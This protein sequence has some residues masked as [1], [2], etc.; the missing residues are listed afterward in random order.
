[1]LWCWWKYCA[2]KGNE[3]CDNDSRRW[4][5]IWHCSLEKGNSQGPQRSIRTY[6]LRPLVL[7]RL[8]CWTW[9]MPLV[10]TK[11][12]IC[13]EALF[14]AC[15][16]QTVKPQIFGASIYFNMEILALPRHL[17]PH[18]W[19]PWPLSWMGRSDPGRLCSVLSVRNQRPWYFRV[20][21]KHSHFGD[22]KP[23]QTSVQHLQ[24][25]TLKRCIAALRVQL[26]CLS[27]TAVS[28]W[29]CGCMPKL[30]Q[31]IDVP[32]LRRDVNRSAARMHDV[33]TAD[34]SLRKNTRWI[35]DFFVDN[36][37]GYVLD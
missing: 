24:V 16:I 17:H 21:H 26:D 18:I 13:V 12:T 36:W 19:L 35:S 28:F 5:Q 34:S 1:M 10:V 27:A 6:N 29:C 4:K 22:K 9:L 3:C 31:R 33:E 20:V 7:K 37:Y 23:R 30:M 11:G 15:S 2:T 25:N 8:T 32:Y 14:L